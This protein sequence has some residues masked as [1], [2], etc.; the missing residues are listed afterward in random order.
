MAVIQRVLDA[1]A[2]DVFAVLADGWTYSDWVVGTAHIRD[3][4]ATWPEPGSE[5][6]HKVGPWPVSVRDST[7]VL[8]CEP[9]RMLL[10]KVRLW[11]LGQGEVRFTLVPVGP[12]RTRVTMAETFTGGP[13]RWVHTKLNDLVV[14]WRNAEAL[15][16]VEDLARSRA[17]DG[18]VRGPNA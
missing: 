18:A 2:D 11:P 6:H 3:V 10:T 9:G 17:V 4:D 16:R 13:L 1:S 5:L 14:H 7:T 15:R 12:Q 8:E